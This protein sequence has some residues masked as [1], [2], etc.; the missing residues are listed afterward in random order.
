[1]NSPEAVA[2]GRAWGRI[3]AWPCWPVAAVVGLAA[4]SS[5]MMH[6]LASSYH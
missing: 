3:M 6:Y 1:M 5:E 2:A 4:L